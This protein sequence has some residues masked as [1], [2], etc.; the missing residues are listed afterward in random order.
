LYPINQHTNYISKNSI[1]LWL[2]SGLNQIKEEEVKN[3][4]YT[5][6]QLKKPNDN[7]RTSLNQGNGNKKF[8]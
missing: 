3:G 4:Q 2:P 6:F 7:N 5:F 1:R 8:V